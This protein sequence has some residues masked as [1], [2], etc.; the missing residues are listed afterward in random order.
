M[1][2]DQRAKELDAKKEAQQ[3]MRD[4]WAQVKQW[5]DEIKWG[6]AHMKLD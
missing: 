4:M 6:L 1:C 5:K 2:P 3:K